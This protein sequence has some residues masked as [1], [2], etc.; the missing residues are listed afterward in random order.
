LADVWV[1]SELCLRG[2]MAKSVETQLQEYELKTIY[3]QK[4][5]YYYSVLDRP[6]PDILTKVYRRANILIK[7][8]LYVWSFDFFSKFKAKS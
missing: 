5:G 6:P 1:N 4:Y 2:L 3:Y 7:V 8:L